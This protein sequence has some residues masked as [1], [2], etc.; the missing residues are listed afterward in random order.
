MRFGTNYNDTLNLL[1]LELLRFSVKFGKHWSGPNFE[2]R[3]GFLSKSRKINEQYINVLTYVLFL[4]KLCVK[5]ESFKA[6]E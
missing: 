5:C 1:Y 2:V 6:I 4:D 3:L